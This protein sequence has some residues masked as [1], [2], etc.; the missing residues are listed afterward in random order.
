MALRA[1]SLETGQPVN[2][3]DEVVDFRGD[4]YRFV[5]AIDV[6]VPGRS[7]KVEVATFA[8]MLHRRTLYASVFGFVVKDE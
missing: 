8:G 1:Y 5:R 6:T 2:P 3:G 4:T 7:G